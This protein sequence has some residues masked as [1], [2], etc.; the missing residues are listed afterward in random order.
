MRK[1]ATIAVGA[2]VALL[3]AGEALAQNAGPV[4]VIPTR[5]DVPVVLYGRD[6]SYV[7]V[8]SDFGLSRPGHLPPAI[9]GYAPPVGDRASPIRGV[10]YPR[11]GVVPPRGRNEVDPG[12]N[13]RLPEPAE[14]FSRSWGTQ[15]PGVVAPPPAYQR[16]LDPIYPTYP[17]DGVPGPHSQNGVPPLAVESTT[18]APATVVDPQTF[19][20]P[21]VV[22]D[23]RRRRP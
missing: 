14:S 8:E 1:L 4:I 22:I 2:A 7:V 13:R 18:V 23:Q 17:N 3:G 10:N 21:P 19:A 6:V 20:M 15:S 9:I 16:P 11:Y 5:R 12:P